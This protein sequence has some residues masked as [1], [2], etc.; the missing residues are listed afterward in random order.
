MGL[1]TI[2]KNVCKCIHKSTRIKSYNN[3]LDKVSAYIVMS[4]TKLFR[5]R[6]FLV[7]TLGGVLYCRHQHRGQQPAM[8]TVTV[9]ELPRLAAGPAVTGTSVCLWEN[10]SLESGDHGDDQSF[11]IVVTRRNFNVQVAPVIR[12]NGAQRGP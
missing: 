5:V 10:R 12:D 4:L 3:H 2:N 11:E 7:Q 8:M 6:R 1:Y 9:M